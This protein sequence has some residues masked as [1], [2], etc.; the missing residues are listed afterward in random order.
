MSF[1]RFLTQVTSSALSMIAAAQR[2]GPD[3]PSLWSPP[4][5]ERDGYWPPHADSDPRPPIP[6][7]PQTRR[8]RLQAP[9][10]VR[11]RHR[12]GSGRRRPG[13]RPVPLRDPHQVR[14]VRGERQ[15][16]VRED[17]RGIRRGRG[18]E[19]GRHRQPERP[20]ARRHHVQHRDRRGLR[21][22]VHGE[23]PDL[24]EHGRARV[25]PGSRV[26]LRRRPVVPALGGVPGAPGHPV[27]PVAPPAVRQL[28]HLRHGGLHI[29][30][31]GGRLQG[32]P[33]PGPAAAGVAGEGGER[34]GDGPW[35]DRPGAG[36]WF[37]V[38][39]VHGGRERRVHGDL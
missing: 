28:H 9:R 33:H 37:C 6:L 24:P 32:L 20:D 7:R 17:E 12:P 21:R 13:L 14:D 3:D 30:Q 19:D 27:R 39:G 26:P 31:L 23:G 4:Q 8:H 35:P 25:P 16:G 34:R 38:R 15:G 10:R 22:R 11:P 18:G 2:Y 36:D 5:T 29:R 1:L